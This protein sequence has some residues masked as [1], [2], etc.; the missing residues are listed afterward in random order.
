MCFRKI[1][2]LFVM[3]FFSVL[4]SLVS[5]WADEPRFNSYD[6]G[7]CYR[8]VVLNKL[9]MKVWTNEYKNIQWVKEAKKRGLDCGVKNNTY[10]KRFIHAALLTSK[11]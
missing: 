1:L 4:L 10:A 7:I 2:M 5:S 8:A 3:S 11:K 6:E 9:N